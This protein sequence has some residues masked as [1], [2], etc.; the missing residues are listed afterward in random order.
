MSDNQ[1]TIDV[2]MGEA[3]AALFAA[4]G[5]AVETE[6]PEQVDGVRLEIAAVI[7]F[8]GSDVRGALMLAMSNTALEASR[9][10]HTDTPRDWIAELSNQLLG[11]IKNLL[12]G[13][14]VDVTISTPLV[15]RGERI[16][17]SMAGDEAPV[18]WTFSNGTAYG[19]LDCEFAPNFVFRKSTHA[20][21]VVSEGESLMF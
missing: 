3:G 14:D 2:L 10:T 7:G 9:Q 12:A 4:Y 18:V 20:A 15:L 17:P 8:T 5:L 6:R 13:Y 1:K 21:E 16:A 19:W 11:R